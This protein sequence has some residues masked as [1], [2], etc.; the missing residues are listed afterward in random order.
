VDEQEGYCGACRDF[1]GQPAGGGAAMSTAFDPQPMPARVLLRVEWAD[2]QVREFEAEKPHSLEFE[3]KTPLWP[4][5]FAPSSPLLIEACE[6]TS[7]KLGFK[8]GAGPARH[9]IAMRTEASMSPQAKLAEIRELAES[10]GDRSS[11]PPGPV[12]DR[13]L[14]EPLRRMLLEILDRP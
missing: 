10:L 14:M 12:S 5:P 11:E 8:A 13:R 9:A 2:G 3:V 6:V 1:T 7:V 4:G